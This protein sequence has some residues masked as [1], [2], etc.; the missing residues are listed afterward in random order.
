[1]AP[2]REIKLNKR[3]PIKDTKN[4]NKIEFSGKMNHAIQL[5]IKSSNSNSSP[6]KNVNYTG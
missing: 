6:L 1:M 3:M 4:L 2:D 5:F